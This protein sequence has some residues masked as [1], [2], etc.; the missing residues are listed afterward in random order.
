MF[1]LFWG[2]NNVFA[3]MGMVRAALWEPE[4]APD[5]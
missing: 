2:L 4:E 5:D 1:S 3:L